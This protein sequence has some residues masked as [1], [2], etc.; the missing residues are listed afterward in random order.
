MSYSRLIAVVVGLCFV[1]MFPAAFAQ[2]STGTIDVFIKSENNDRVFPQGVTIKVFKDLE[3]L[4]IQEILSVENNPLSI[5]SLPLGHRYSIEVY[6]N[7]MYA[8]VGFVDL[9]K[10]KQSTE[11]TI[12]NMGGMRLNVFY[13]DGQTPLS[14][15]FVVIKSQ[16]GKSWH[17]SNTDQFGNSIRAWL[18]PSI[19]DN[20]YYFAEIS[21][22]PNLKFTTLPIKLQSSVAQDFKIVTTW[23][24]II[25]KLITVEVYNSTKTKVTKQDGEFVAQLLDAKKNKIAESQVTDKG[26]AHF[27][28]LKV[29]NYALYIKSKDDNGQLQTVVGKKV[30]ITDKTDTIKIYLNNPELNSDHLTCNCVAF[31]LDDI[32]DFY[33]APAQLAVISLFEQKNVPLT[34]GIIGGVIGTDQKLISTIKTGMVSNTTIEVASHSWNNKILTTLTKKEQEELIT[35]T[36]DKIMSVFGIK[37]K[38]FIP[39]ENVFNNDTLSVLKNNGFT[40]ISYDATEVDPPPFKKSDFYH[41][42]IVP[43]T[44][45]LDAATG[46]WHPL[47]NEQIVDKIEQSLFDY[48][49]A[50]VMMHPYEFSVYENG[51]YINQ[52]NTTKIKE[53]ESLI[54][55]IQSK[56]LKILPIG[57]IENYDV[58]PTDATTGDKLL[59]SNCNCL[60][61]RLDNVQDYWLND[62]Q[63][64]LLDTF[65]KKEVPLTIAVLGKFIGDD[66]KVVGHIQ[67]KLEN[68]SPNL[69]IANRG[70]EHI[71]H[72]SYDVERQAASIKQTNEKINKMFE[73]TATVFVPPYDD[74]NQDTIEAVKQNKMLYLSSNVAKEKLPLTTD[75]P[76]HIPST[77]SFA[78]LV[79]DDPFLSGT[80]SEKAL[81]KVR[82]GL[83][84]YGF[85]VIS[86]QP[87]D[88]AVKTG[89]FQNE[90]DAN[91]LRHLEQLIDD[92]RAS[93]IDIVL[94]EKVPAL[95]D[96]STIV[97]PDWIKNNAAWWAQDK[98]GD[99]DFTKGLEYL[100]KQK[101]IKI[102]STQQGDNVG[103]KIPSWIKTNAAWWAEGKIGNSDFVKGIQYLIQKGIITI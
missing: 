70:W 89:E 54:E 32:Q 29:N 103:Q 18:Y 77:E 19:K 76:R 50:V 55:T 57:S 87:S 7:S 62:V 46:I 41:F 22:G 39:P 79:S 33:L 67:E 30:L 16:D 97:I 81:Q 37:P 53:L 47:S 23:P 84:R 74:F 36:N 1:A 71:D 92:V 49:Y 51:F 58:I 31:R 101:I 61:F 56:N 35:K 98:I 24:T 64:T 42:P 4:P 26:L 65:E 48:G 52:V 10:S 12:K 8:G 38:T 94:L 20:N 72:T 11:I 6:V 78:N 9:Q 85:A 95:L 5:S 102:P 13:N 14:G 60:A 69:R 34:I 43:T 93:G 96:E 44:A 75:A 83:T 82:S 100:I 27:S 63:N 91:K 3:S 25:D 59:T 40:H 17:T 73:T 86:M 80:I 15:A 45:D 90:M 21:L 66:P 68:N 99:A 88:F 28:K 2:Q